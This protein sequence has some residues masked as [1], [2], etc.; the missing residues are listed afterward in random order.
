MADI[1]TTSERESESSADIGEFSIISTCALPPSAEEVVPSKRSFVLKFFEKRYG[2]RAVLNGNLTPFGL[3]CFI[4]CIE[5]GGHA[6]WNMPAWDKG[7]ISETY[8]MFP[9]KDPLVW[10]FYCIQKAQMWDA[11]EIDLLTD[12]VPFRALNPRYRQMVAEILAF[13]APGDGLISRQ[14]IRYLTEA[15]NYEETAFLNYQN[16]IETTHSEGYG[17][18]ITIL[19]PDKT[20]QEAIFAAV[21]KVPFITAK[22]HFV[23]KWM[24]S[25]ASRGI[26]F[27]AGAAA[28]G[29]FFAASFSVIF[30]I[31]AKGIIPAFSFLNEQVSKDEVVHRDFNARMA[32]RYKEFTRDNVIAILQEAINIE[33]DFL[34][35]LLR[36]P[37][38]SHEADAIG[39]LTLENLHRFICGLADQILIQAGLGRHFTSTDGTNGTVTEYN[40]PWMKDLSIG[41]Q[42]SFYEAKVGSYKRTSFTHAVNWRKRC[43]IDEDGNEV[44]EKS[45]ES[46]IANPEE[47]T[48]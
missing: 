32:D 18:M 23:E 25:D 26:R 30:Y 36:T 10:E 3:D 45:P 41:R 22:A 39:G 43:G 21:D 1:A 42:T 9:I 48:F 37:L 6:P 46:C 24:E 17:M 31:R 16:A 19:F 7:S 5:A 11:A 34:R 13:F 28:E 15:S 20:E 8:S 35:Y 47:V 14:V 2:A 27:I 44:V 33:M 4:K 29:I 12:R 38:D 40:P